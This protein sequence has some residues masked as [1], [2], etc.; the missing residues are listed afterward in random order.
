MIDASLVKTP[1]GRLAEMLILWPIGWVLGLDVVLPALFVLI[2]GGMLWRDRIRRPRDRVLF[3]MALAMAVLW[4]LPIGHIPARSRHL[5]IRQL[6]TGFA[7]TGFLMI[8]ASRSWNDRD[9]TNV[10]RG[11]TVLGILTITG[12]LLYAWPIG[13]VSIPT[14]VGRFIPER[15]VAQSFFWQTVAVHAVGQP[16]PESGLL[17]YRVR[18]FADTPAGLSFFLC[19]WIPYAIWR[20]GRTRGWRRAGWVIVTGL[21]G[22]T[23]GLNGTRMLLPALGM[24]LIFF[25]LFRGLRGFSPDE[26]RILWRRAAIGIAGGCLL[27]GLGFMSPKVRGGVD[28]FFLKTRPSSA[29]VRMRIVRQT[30]QQWHRHPLVGWGVPVRVQGQGKKYSAGT[31]SMVLM[32]LFQHGLVGL[33]LYAGIWGRFW[34]RLWR[35]WATWNTRRTMS[36]LIMTA[37]IGF[38]VRELTGTWMWDPLVMVSVW[39]FL[40]LISTL[41]PGA[42]QRPVGHEGLTNGGINPLA[43]RDIASDGLNV[44]GTEQGPTV[45][46]PPNEHQQ[47][48]E[49]NHRRSP[50]MRTKKDGKN[51]RV[52]LM[53]LRINP[54]TWPELKARILD[55]ARNHRGTVIG[56]VNAHALNLARRNPDFHGFLR[57]CDVVFC[58]GEGVRLAARLCGHVIPERMTYPDVIFELAAACAREGLSWYLLGAR[59]GVAERAAR[60]LN[61]RVP[62]LRIA[63]WHHGYF[64]PQPGS[65]ADEAVVAAINAVQPDVL[66]VCFG[67]PRQERWIQAHRKRLKVGVMLPAGALLDYVAGAVRRSPGWLNRHGL[68]WFGRL[69]IEPRRLWRRYLLGLP[70]FF[71]AVIR[72]KSRIRKHEGRASR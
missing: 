64:D 51:H 11:L 1:S 5:F 17:W 27:L 40:A 13:R 60:R 18:A 8:L 30:R 16:A 68:E 26:R 46:Y 29:H 72:Y 38:H 41:T 49:S 3:G 6:M 52:E 42:A 39:A 4:V 31:H 50:T 21:S 65:P 22:L 66:F 43:R 53:G 19:L 33:F 37:L 24:A 55:D 63:G 34:W 10:I 47:I 59:P 44:A 62:Q 45:G 56:N 14:T 12:G 9:R 48:S 71:Y 57:A 15:L 67:M 23:A 28:R 7:Y 35:A 61:A 2:E 25:G 70:R 20:L 36:L 69:W 32:M 58:D 54:V